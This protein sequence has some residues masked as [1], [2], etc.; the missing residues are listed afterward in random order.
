[1]ATDGHRSFMQPWSE[2]I[3]AATY[4]AKPYGSESAHFHGN[5]MVADI[6]CQHREVE[7]LEWVGFSG[8]GKCP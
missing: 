6:D 1:M 8:R 4:H 7:L 2:G 3:I 5:F